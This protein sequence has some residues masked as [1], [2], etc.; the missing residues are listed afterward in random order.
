MQ[1]KVHT[2]IPEIRSNNYTFLRLR[3]R[4]HCCGWKYELPSISVLTSLKSNKNGDFSW[5]I[6]RIRIIIMPYIDIVMPSVI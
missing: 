3:E 1:K 6:T 4:F 5:G 2:F